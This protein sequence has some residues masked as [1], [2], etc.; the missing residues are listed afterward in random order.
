MVLDPKVVVFYYKN[1][2]DNACY[3]NVRNTKYEYNQMP[4]YYAQSVFVLLLCIL[5]DVRHSIV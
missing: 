1:E 2:H 3:T 4:S 5:Q